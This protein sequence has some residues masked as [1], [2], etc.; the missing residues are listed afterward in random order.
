MERAGFE[1]T[2]SAW[3]RS[4]LHW[5]REIAQPKRGCIAVLARSEGA[6][7][8]GFYLSTIGAEIELLGGNQKDAVNVGRFPRAQVLGYRLPG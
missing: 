1:G 2:D 7:H 4:W 8:V 3:A 6:G 5:G